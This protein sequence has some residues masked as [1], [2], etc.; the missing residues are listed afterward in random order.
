MKTA[1]IV[2]GGITVFCVVFELV[3]RIGGRLA[4]ERF[5]KMTPEERSRYQND[6]RKAEL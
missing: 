1:F 2:A 3:C 6:I 5:D 4:K